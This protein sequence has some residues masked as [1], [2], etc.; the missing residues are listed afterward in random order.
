[1]PRAANP[2]A[3]SQAAAAKA[4]LCCTTSAAASRCMGDKVYYAAGEAVL[5]A[6]DAKTG[7]EVWTTTVADNKAGYYI[8]LA[9]LIAGRQGDGRRFGRR[10]WNPRLHRGLRSRNRQGTMAD[11][12][13]FRLRRAGQRNLA[14]GRPMEDTAA[15]RSGSR[16][17]TIP[18]RTWR[19]GA[20]ATA[21]PGWATSGPAIISTPA[22]TIAIDV[23]TGAIKGHYQYTSNDS[24][25]WDEVSPPIL[26]DYPAQRPHHQ[27]SDRCR[28]RRLRVVHRSRRTAAHQVH[29]RQAVRQSERV[30]SLDPETG[31]PDVDPAHKP[32][33]GKRADFCP[34]PARRQELA[35]HRVQPADAD[36]L[37]SREQQRLRLHYGPGRCHLRPGQRLLRG[38]FRWRSSACAE[39]ADHFGE[40]QAWNVDTGQRVWTHNYAKSPN[41]GGMLATA[42][43]LVISG[44][45]N[46]R[47]IHAFDAK[48]ASCCGSSHQQRRRAARHDVVVDGKQYI[49]VLSG[50]GGDANGMNRHDPADRDRSPFGARRRL[51][52]GV[53][54]GVVYSGRL[55][56][57][58]PKA[59]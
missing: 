57:V 55:G 52:L 2:V 28:A 29:R 59:A 13:R 11:V 24:W 39:G 16:A 50:W 42:G 3:L 53:R 8:S 35:S 18:I 22:S 27:G 48:A 56:R 14:Q 58:L 41:W 4:P 25:D 47:K 20:S 40:V 9:P 45:T 44:G 12:H 23:A 43:G 19:I 10:D 6:L 17:T 38:V 49:A 7:R 32:G 21:V 54:A 30:T 34:R 36:D 15:V 31:R 26:V 51:G 46:D 5:V 1:M 33:T 37:H